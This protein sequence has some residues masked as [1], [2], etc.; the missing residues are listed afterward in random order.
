MA[1]RAGLHNSIGKLPEATRPRVMEPLTD[2]GKETQYT[3]FLT[4]LTK[5]L[6]KPVWVKK[7]KLHQ[8]GNIKVHQPKMGLICSSSSS[9][10]NEYSTATVVS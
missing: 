4:P 5:S 10:A 2:Q 8:S 1:Q 9:P 3:R 7:Y 6:S